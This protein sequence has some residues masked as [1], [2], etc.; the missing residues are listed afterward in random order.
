MDLK[1]LAA[2][3]GG[4]PVAQP[5][6]DLANLAKQFG[7]V[8]VPATPEAPQD[9]LAALAQQFGG[10]PVDRASTTPEVTEQP[11]TAKEQ[12]GSAFESMGTLG[13]MGFKT[14]R[15]ESTMDALIGPA[16]KYS[17]PEALPVYQKKRELAQQN[18]DAANA[19]AQRALNT[20]A[21]LDAASEIY[22]NKLTP[23][24]VASS[25]GNVEYADTLRQQIKNSFVR[26]AMGTAASALD[27]AALGSAAVGAE[28]TAQELLGK[29]REFEDISGLYPSKY[30]SVQDALAE[31]K[32][33]SGKLEGLATRALEGGIENAPMLLESLMGAAGARYL[34]TRG[35]EA[36]AKKYGKEA[37]EQLLEKAGKW[38]TVAGA[39]GT[40]T[41]L[42]SGEIFRSIYDETGQL[43][44]GV[45][46]GFGAIAGA[47]DAI[48]PAQAI[49]SYAKRELIE[50]LTAS[51]AKRYGINALKSMGEEGATEFL[52]TFIEKAGLT[53]VDG[54]PLFTKANLDQAL[55]AAFVGTVLGG[56]VSVGSQAIQDLANMG[57]S[58]DVLAQYYKDE[59]VAED[60]KKAALDEWGKLRGLSKS[61]EAPE[62]TVPVVEQAA[63][64]TPGVT[65]AE[66]PETP[67]EQADRA[68]MAQYYMDLGH[69]KENAIL[70]ADK[71]LAEREAQD[72]DRTD[73][74]TTGES[75][76]VPG[77][78]LETGAPTGAGEPIGLGVAGAGDV[79]GAA[80][81]GEAEQL[82]TLEKRV[83]EEPTYDKELLDT[84][85][86]ALAKEI[87]ELKAK[88]AEMKP[89]SEE[90]DNL[91]YEI[92]RKEKQ[93]R[94]A[95]NV[96]KQ[97]AKEA[98]ALAET[99]EEVA[100]ED[101]ELDNLNKEAKQLANAIYKIDPQHQL[102]P[103]L[104]D[105][106]VNI[107]DV[108][109]AK[110]ELANLQQE[111]GAPVVV[112][113]ETAATAQEVRAALDEILAGTKAKQNAVVV[114]SYD[115]LPEN[116]RQQALDADARAF[117]DPNT[118]IDYYI[119]SAIGKDE[120]KGTILHERGVHLGLTSLV[121]EDRVTALANRVTNWAATKG[122]KI[123]TQIALEAV[124]AADASK[125]EKGS[126]R[127]NEEVV[128]YFTELAVN[129]YGIDPTKSQP[130]QKQKVKAWL[131]DLWNAVTAALKKLNVN[132]NIITPEDF[133]NI[134]YA[135]ARIPSGKL[136]DEMAG[137]IP[138]EVK[139]D[140]KAL[141]EAEGLV[142]KEVTSEEKIKAAK[143]TKLRPDAT[144]EKI[145]LSEYPS[146]MMSATGRMIRARNFEAAKTSLRAI[147]M[148][149][150][151]NK[152]SAS[153]FTMTTS[154]ITDLIGGEIP[155]LRDLNR[156]VQRMSAMRTRMLAGMA[157]T[158]DPWVKFQRKSPEGARLL[159][160]VMH[161]TT[162]SSDIGVDPTRYATAQEFIANDPG[163]RD[164]NAKM[165][166][167]TDARSRAAYLGNIN[168]RMRRINTAYDLWNQLGKVA[169]GEGQ[170][171]FKR[172][173]EH[174]KSNFE[175]HR[176]LLDDMIAQANVPGTVGDAS[177]PKG[178]LMAAIRRTYSDN[179]INGVYFPLVRYGNFW[180]SVG[181]GAN[182][183]FYMFESQI[184]RN[185]FL[186]DRVKQLQ[187]AGDLRT[188][189]QM[190]EDL[191]LDYGN[192]LT[193][194][195]KVQAETSE[196]LKEIFTIIDTQGVADKESLKDAVYQMY[197]MTLP[198]REF[199]KQFV[200]RKGT[201]GFSG[202]VLRNFVRTGY[203]AASQLSRLKYQSS[204]T[205]EMDAAHAALV[206]N[207]DKPKLEIYLNAIGTRIGEEMHPDQNT[208]LA[209]RIANG[210]N[211]FTYLW[212]LANPRAAMTNL[213]AIPIYGLPVLG[214]Q[215]GYTKATIAL[216]K[217]MNVYNHTTFIK[218]DADGNG[219]YT[220]LS[221]GLSKHVQSNP[222]LAAAF[223]VAA[224]ELNITEFTRAYDMLS[225][226]RTPTSAYQSPFR[227]GTRFAV[228]TMGALFHHTE[229]LNREVMF[230]T[231]FELAYERALEQ[232]L[233]PG[234][235]REAFKKAIDEAEQ[236][237]YRSMFNY[238]PYDRPA[239]MRG[240]AKR[241]AFQFALYKQQQLAYYIRNYYTLLKGSD[242][243]EAA[244]KVAFKQLIG[245]MMLTASFAG[246]TGVF[247]FNAF[248]IMVAAI[249]G[250][251]NGLRDDD[252]PEYLEDRDVLLWFKNSFLPEYFG[253]GSKLEKLFGTPT[254]LTTGRPVKWSTIIEK[255]PIS[256]ISGVDIAS[257]TSQAD[258]WFRDT[259]YDNNSEAM[260]T[261]MIFSQI[262]AAGMVMNIPRAYDDF[263]KGY[264]TEGMN[265]LLPNGLKG[266]V[267]Q[268]M[269]AEEGIVTKGNRDM[270]LYPEEITASMR[271][272]KAVGFNPTELSRLRDSNYRFQTLINK[273]E[274]ERAAILNRYYLALDRGDSDKEFQK[275]FDRIE[276]FNKDN[277][278]EAYIIDADTLGTSIQNREELRAKAYRGV[279]VPEDVMPD[280][281]KLL[282][283][284]RP[285]D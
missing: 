187:D 224:N 57:V 108:N 7:G 212:L 74:D 84:D 161:Y 235:G 143:R 223:D 91:F 192:D 24:A 3:Y 265:R 117:V 191:D 234:V 196:M 181:K 221:V 100:P 194:L 47:L 231:S 52:Q 134:V 211:Q 35:A 285:E 66:E 197:L 213:T 5:K 239:V 244:R 177:T 1:E 79:T 201:A 237:T 190:Q 36:W 11:P 20:G 13:R 199:R 210:A 22:T 120:I 129:K 233:A 41:A 200:H 39:Y 58:R 207:P 264:V 156:Q 118:G 78:P 92:T 14:D 205:A 226:A 269:W 180:V 236:Y 260:L 162:L 62:V 133:V 10:V 184:D 125:E 258:I 113:G 27:I 280:M 164:L 283:P 142:Q 96:Q 31:N 123:E 73:I 158:V 238:T 175:L 144:L 77:G 248:M 225:M 54:R 281:Y 82:D 105:E 259:R 115:Q 139:E 166:A 151:L 45:S 254:D 198:E 220:P 228:K 208:D 271:F 85:V 128:A 216:G 87:K 71:A 17:G 18:I 48:V 150:D 59:K 145:K 126:R 98:A 157:N 232:G 124:L 141:K 179:A 250:M 121:G 202:D 170:R 116:L 263:R 257:S 130:L 111:V 206:G 178:R 60:T 102:I 2:K 103:V 279:R 241:V 204:I 38:G 203:S 240:P 136:A 270:L 6:D 167:A 282:A 160:R 99:T 268:N 188:M 247:G 276:K 218:R 43:R 243:D 61:P 155:H 107:D 153:T 25:D 44:P 215:F 272:W 146:Q 230:M 104:R 176:V 275:I 267:E 165:N 252:E 89:M 242:L 15:N 171:I 138:P 80:T 227:R 183:E 253:E 86:K 16:S 152:I 186:Q 172:V 222:I 83:E 65:P 185:L 246:V 9:N 229:R 127:Y 182:K 154:Q 56:G 67:I 217:Y 168:K 284:S 137:A 174:Y 4:T 63:A 278:Y 266:I 109:F 97:V 75:T 274:D 112:P 261:D 249:Q 76:G 255:G 64:V 34:A 219:T 149:G 163:M 8:P 148:A 95:K 195:R 114:D 93:L 68:G 53:F 273:I 131:K 12:I 122:N 106:M 46:L 69:T 28:G 72:V 55:D 132:T 37:T 40:S 140:L 277:P 30:R 245:T 23:I 50:N 193:K 159:G 49:N 119:A 251:I 81:S 32:D 21:S 51:I 70:L 90:E 19:E 256:A 101:I 88:R 189:Q 29:A 94:S 169:N 42:E 110:Q 147:Y 26:G 135:A 209:E 262:P 33:L 173:K 214:S